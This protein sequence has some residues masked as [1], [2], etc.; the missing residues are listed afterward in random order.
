MTTTA[1]EVTFS[2]RQQAILAHVKNNNITDFPA[3][4]V[5]GGSCVNGSWKCNTEGEAQVYRAYAAVYGSYP[6]SPSDL[7]SAE[8][9]TT[10]EVS[11]Y[12]VNKFQ[13][14]KNVEGFRS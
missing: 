8:G 7:R 11:A 13:H 5:M 2:K 12:L 6:C 10:T 1:T 9:Y 4:R 14:L 3:L